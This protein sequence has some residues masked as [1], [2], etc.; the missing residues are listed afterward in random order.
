LDKNKPRV[1]H[2]ARKKE[3][4]N[5]EKKERKMKKGTENETRKI[6]VVFFTIVIEKFNGYISAITVEHFNGCVLAIT[7]E[8]LVDVF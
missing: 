2:G 7:A 4:K 3:R 8:N 1:I 6:M 5:V